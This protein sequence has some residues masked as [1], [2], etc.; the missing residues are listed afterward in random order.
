MKT[1]LVQK[2]IILVFFSLIILLTSI[3]FSNYSPTTIWANI[4]PPFKGHSELIIGKISDVNNNH[5]VGVNNT[6]LVEL[7]LVNLNITDE[8]KSQDATHFMSVVCPIRSPVVVMP[9]FNSPYILSH[10]SSE[11]LSKI[12]GIVFCQSSS[13]SDINTTKSIN[14][15]LVDANL[16]TLDNKSCINF[17]PIISQWFRDLKC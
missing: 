15:Q 10:S 9:E 17:E 12:K 5:T 1:M 16:A 4:L 14:E 13:I 3:G 8:I 7:A 6:L 2:F 11:N